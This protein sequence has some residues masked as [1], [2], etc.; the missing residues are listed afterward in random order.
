MCT[1]GV[2]RGPEVTDRARKRLKPRAGGPARQMLMGRPMGTPVQRPNRATTVNTRKLAEAVTNGKPKDFDKFEA[3]AGLKHKKL[4]DY[5][6]R[7][8]L[9][10]FR[11][12]APK[13]DFDEN[14]AFDA[15]RDSKAFGYLKA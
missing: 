10:I 15:V 1:E 6:R 7:A 8:M 14:K 3:L 9:D 2:R 4:N 11:R 12:S 13:N 5:Q